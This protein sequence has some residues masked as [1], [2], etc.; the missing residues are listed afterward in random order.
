MILCSTIWAKTIILAAMKKTLTLILTGFFFWLTSLAGHSEQTSKIAGKIWK[1]ECGGKRDGLTTWNKGENFG[2]YGIGHF[3]W[4]P[5][6]KTERFQES[7]PELL[8]YLQNNGIEFP[9]WLK[10]SQGSPWENRDDFYSKFNTTEMTEL[11]QLLYETRNLQADFIATRLDKALPKMIEKLVDSEKEKISITYQR[12]ADTPEGL[13]AMIDYVNFKG[14]G[15]SPS[16]GYKGQ[17]WGLLQ[18]LERIPLSSSN[19]LDDFSEVAKTVLMQRVE[20]SPRERN[21]KQWLQGWINRVNSYR[22]AF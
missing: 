19:V 21:E 20:N 18:V 22:E 10:T 9:L 11:R 5:Q 13:Y 17:G 16:E 2:S 12:L 3:I 6:G 15:L 4:Y 7:F 1:N 14:E 8:I